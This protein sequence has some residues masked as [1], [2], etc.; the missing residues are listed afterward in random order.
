M[1]TAKFMKISFILLH[2][3]YYSRRALR[4]HAYAMMRHSAA[5]LHLTIGSIAAVGL[6]ICDVTQGF[7]QT[8]HQ[9][10]MTPATNDRLTVGSV[11]SSTGE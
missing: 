10:F 3:H 9:C 6:E 2:M 11:V 8:S 1:Q 5:L 4:L 7:P